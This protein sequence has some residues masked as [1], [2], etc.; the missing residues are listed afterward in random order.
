MR[1]DL[2]SLGGVVKLLHDPGVRQN[3]NTLFA[4][5]V[6][7]YPDLPA[8]SPSDPHGFHVFQNPIFPQSL[9]RS[10]TMLLSDPSHI[11]A[12]ENE[13][14]PQFPLF[15]KGYLGDLTDSSIV[16]GIILNLS[17]ALGRIT[18]NN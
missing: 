14:L 1:L 5:R 10:P 15:P 13:I 7:L 16:D 6:C 9:Q 17:R 8:M 11:H 4:L 18:L 12:F 2:D 3:I